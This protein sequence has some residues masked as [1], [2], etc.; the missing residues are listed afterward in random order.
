MGD[1]LRLAIYFAIA[2]GL[3]FLFAWFFLPGMNPGPLRT[4]RCEAH[5]VT[6]GDWLERAR[7]H[8]HIQARMSLKNVGE[9]RVGLIVAAGRSRPRLSV[10]HKL[11]ESCL[12][13]G[14]TGVPFVPVD[15]W[16]IRGNRDFALARALYLESGEVVDI[17]IVHSMCKVPKDVYEK[18]D[19]EGRVALR[20]GLAEMGLVAITRA[21]FR[22]LLVRCGF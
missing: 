14:L 12:R 11:A 5:A 18:V 10:R 8:V 16:S 7:P 1:A 9:T 4:V 21:G 20:G 17:T 22:P 6:R 2:V 13:G 15:D 3:L 19:R